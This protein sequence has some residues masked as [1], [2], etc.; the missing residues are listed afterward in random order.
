M[1][2]K[3]YVVWHG[4]TPGIY[5]S[6]HECHAQII[7]YKG[8]KFKS[9]ETYEEAA[10]AFA[11]PPDTVDTTCGLK[12]YKNCS[13]AELVEGFEYAIFC[14]GGCY[15][16][17]GPAGT[18][19]AIYSKTAFQRGFFGCFQPEGTNNTAEIYGI[20]QALDFIDFLVSD[21]GYTNKVV[22]YSDSQYALNSICNWGFNWAKNGWRKSNDEPIQNVAMIRS[23]HEAYKELKDF[24]E[25]RHV[26]GHSGIEGNEIAD[27]LA[28]LARTSKEMGWVELTDLAELHAVAS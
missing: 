10:E 12:S 14:D 27:Q 11:N 16:N 13:M 24:V 28:T 21:C 25:F 15:P 9:F 19:M 23:A 6:W 18:G 8:A 1:Q 7:G 20:L 22:V 26:K 5:G 17:P 3:H 2:T 4:R